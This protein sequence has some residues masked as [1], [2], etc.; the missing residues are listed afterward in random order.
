MTKVYCVIFAVLITTCQH[1]SEEKKAPP[2]EPAVKSSGLVFWM[3]CGATT[4]RISKMLSCPVEDSNCVDIT[5]FYNYVQDRMD[6]CQAQ[7][8]IAAVWIELDPT[9]VS[10]T[11]WNTWANHAKGT[12]AFLKMNHDKTDTIEASLHKLVASVSDIENKI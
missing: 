7:K 6:A 4:D 1:G 8:Q 2:I 11:I 9:K 3:G 10:R 12:L 5:S